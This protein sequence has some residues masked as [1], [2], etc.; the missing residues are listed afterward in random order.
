V[1]LGD[2]HDVVEAEGERASARRKLFT[3]INCGF[4]RP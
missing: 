2:S 4:R 1:D 3:E